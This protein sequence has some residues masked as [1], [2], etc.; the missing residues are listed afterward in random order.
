MIG[1]D[2]AY[3]KFRRVLVV[4]ANWR[5]S[6]SQRAYLSM[7]I[8]STC[9]VLFRHTHIASNPVRLNRVYGNGMSVISH[10]TSFRAQT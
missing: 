7:Y 9:I 1:N 2:N 5:D 6:H 4:K 10:F 8:V 3:L